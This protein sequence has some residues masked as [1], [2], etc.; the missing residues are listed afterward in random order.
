M[1][2]ADIFSGKQDGE[3]SQG[4]YLDELNTIFSHNQLSYLQSFCGIASIAS[5][6]PQT[7]AL[8][9]CIIGGVRSPFRAG[10]EDITNRAKQLATLSLLRNYVGAI[11][12]IALL[13]DNHRPVILSDLIGRW[14]DRELQEGVRTALEK[15]Y[16]ISFVKKFFVY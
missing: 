5:I 7:Y 4:I 10:P 9:D 2:I 15:S 8:G 12:A 14:G 3:W 16:G 13:S 1:P 11:L 6:E